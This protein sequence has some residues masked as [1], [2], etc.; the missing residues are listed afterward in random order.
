[1]P[2]YSNTRNGQ[3]SIEFIAIFA[4][5]LVPLLMAFFYAYSIISGSGA[6]RIDFSLDR[7][8]VAAERLYAQGP[9]ASAVVYIDLPSGLVSNGS[10][11]GNST[12]GV[13]GYLTLNVSGAEAFRLLDAQ[14]SGA[15]PGMA[16]GWVKSGMTLMNLSVNASGVVNINPR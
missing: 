16:G 1:M 3:V 13:G 8:E 12:N 4:L 5:M 11:V 9:G 7:L 10:Y 2:A 6:Y 14:V 15:W